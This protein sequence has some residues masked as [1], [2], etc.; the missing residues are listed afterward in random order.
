LVVN[1]L[2]GFLALLLAFLKVGG[3]EGSPDAQFS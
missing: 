1:P 2:S 3:D